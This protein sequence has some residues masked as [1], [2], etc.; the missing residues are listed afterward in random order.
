MRDKMSQNR[1]RI[2]VLLLFL[3]LATIPTAL[4]TTPSKTDQNQVITGSDNGNTLFLKR[5]D[6]FYLQLKENPSTGYS[7]QLQLS[8][9]LKL[10][11]DKYIPG[12]TR[13]CGAP[14]TH[15]WAIKAVNNGWQS[16]KGTYKRPWKKT[17][18]KDQTF[19]FN[20]KVK[21]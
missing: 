7:W 2:T 6:T 1:L 10:K 18:S 11:N 19:K 3:I 9:G 8:K 12:T 13:L 5:G 21:K 14:G 17:T 15:L 16:V 20:V 4:C